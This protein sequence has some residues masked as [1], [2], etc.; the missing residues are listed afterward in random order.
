[1]ILVDS[2]IL[3]RFS[4]GDY[5]AAKWLETNGVNDELLVSVVSQL[6]LLVGSRDKRHLT[7]IK[8][9]LSRFPVIELT[10]DI[11]EQLN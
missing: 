4:R 3:I 6:E 8:K 7:E 5:E 1:M 10:P 9:F 2:N 11:G